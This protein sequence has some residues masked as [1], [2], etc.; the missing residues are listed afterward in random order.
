MGTGL[1]KGRYLYLLSG[2]DAQ[3]NVLRSFCCIGGL[4]LSGHLACRRVDCLCSVSDSGSGQPLR[5]FAGSRGCI[6][7]AD[8]RS[9]EV[10]VFL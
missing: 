3:L 5:A 7:T 8:C 6:E 10:A 9:R 2:I 1:R 4:S